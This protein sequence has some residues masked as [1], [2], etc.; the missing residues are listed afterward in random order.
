MAYLAYVSGGSASVTSSGLLTVSVGGRPTRSNWRETIRRRPVPARARTP[1][2]ARW[3]RRRPRAV[4]PQRHAHPDGPRRGRG[5]GSARRRPGPTVLGEDAGADHLDRPPRGGLRAPSEAAECLAGAR[6][7]RRVRAGHGRT[8]DLFLSPDHAVYVNDVLIPIRHL[9]NGSTIAQ[10]PMDR[11]TYY[12]LELAQ[13]DVVLAQGLPAESFLDMRDGA[14]LR[15]PSRAGPAV[16][17]S[18]RTHVGG[19]RLRTADRHGTGTCGGAGAGRTFRDGSASR[20][21]WKA[22]R[23]PPP[24]RSDRD[25]TVAGGRVYM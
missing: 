20:V 25:H 14:E 16:S 6:R 12:H 5:G 8:R 13:H 3:S 7:R 9:I 1:A 15:E 17:G 2:A 21:G 24:E 23:I 18:F 10:V 22:Q 19:V 11:V 4:L